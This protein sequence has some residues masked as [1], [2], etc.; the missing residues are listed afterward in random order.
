MG[1]ASNLDKLC[2]ICTNDQVEGVL[3]FSDDGKKLY[4]EAKMK[5]YLYITV[6]RFGSHIRLLLSIAINRQ[7]FF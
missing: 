6:S 3:I 4:L 2:R 1:T 7:R 5:K